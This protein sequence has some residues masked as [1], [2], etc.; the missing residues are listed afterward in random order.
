MHGE[1]LKLEVK[2]SQYT[3]QIR[4][5]PRSQKKWSYSRY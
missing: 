1:N 3:K 2:I 4:S 5:Q